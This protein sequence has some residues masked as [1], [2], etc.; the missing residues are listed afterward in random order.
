M[1]KQ[2]LTRKHLQK[3]GV[4]DVSTAVDQYQTR[5]VVIM[6]K[7]YYTLQIMQHIAA[8]FMIQSMKKL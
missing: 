3:H 8:C 2:Y 7:I 6:T 5:F 4:P 1:V